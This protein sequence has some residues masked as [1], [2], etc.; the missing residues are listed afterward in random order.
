MII[1]PMGCFPPFLW[2]VSMA[3]VYQEIGESGAE[4]SYDAQFL[5]LM[6]LGLVMTFL[7]PKD[8]LHL[9][10]KYSSEGLP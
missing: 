8:L 3:S 10:D 9:S 5:P 4:I 7:L 1:L 2:D 6:T